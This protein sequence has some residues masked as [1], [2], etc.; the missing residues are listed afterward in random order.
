MLTR[1]I[2]ILRP[3]RQ[4]D[5]GDIF[6]AVRESLAEISPWLS[7]A[8]KDYS[9][10][11]TREWLRARPRDWKKGTAYDFAILDVRDGTFLGGCG[12]NAIDNEN[13]RANLGY[14]VRTGRTGQ[15]VATIATL[16]LS[17]W[18]F[19]ELALKR[20]EIL[21]ATGNKHSQRVAAKVGAKREGILRNRITVHDATYDAIMYSLIPGD[22]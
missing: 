11:E 3:Y 17:E 6:E 2:V 1:G 10:K 8:H 4:S 14:W 5:A 9:I 19:K 7:F 13:H 16:L 18:S 20:V 15:G 22:I 12:L 21:V